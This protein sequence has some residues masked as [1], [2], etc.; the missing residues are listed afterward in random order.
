MTDEAVACILDPGSQIVAISS[1]K[2]RELAL[3]YNPETQ[4]RMQSANG[5]FDFTRG[6]AENVPVEL[7][8]G[9]TIFLQMH[10]VDNAAYD[11]LLGRPF[12]VLTMCKAENGPDGSHEITITCP[13]TSKKVT[14]PTYAR[15][16]VP[17]ALTEPR[18]VFP[19][20][21]N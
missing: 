10:V 21:M 11:I 20:S 17:R 3:P 18:S 16:R 19:A 9:I 1:D 2:A 13:N 8:G 5:T 7:R 12:E 14:I 15:G 6:V 4:I